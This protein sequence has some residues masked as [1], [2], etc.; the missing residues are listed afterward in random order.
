MSSRRSPHMSTPRSS[1]VTDHFYTINATE[2]NVAATTEGYVE[3]GIQCYVL[4]NALTESTQSSAQSSTQTSPQTSMQSSAQTSTP[5][6]STQ[7]SN[8]TTA[9]TPTEARTQIPTQ[10]TTPVVPVPKSTGHVAAIVAPIVAVVTVFALLV[11]L[12]YV[13]FRRR[14]RPIRAKLEARGEDG[15]V[16]SASLLPTSNSVDAEPQVGILVVDAEVPVEGA[17]NVRPKPQVHSAATSAAIAC[18]IYNPHRIVSKS[19][20]A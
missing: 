9:Q 11:I 17:L 14:E 12:I 4:P 20:K 13:W 1:L 18:R 3:E 15:S 2:M 19:M 7:I 16:S 10:N 6:T 5:Q 8:Q